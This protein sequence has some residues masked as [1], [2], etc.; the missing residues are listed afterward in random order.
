M[1]VE[2]ARSAAACVITVVTR[3]VRAAAG[4]FAPG[5]LGE[6]IQ[7]VP[8]EMVDAVLAE[9]GGIQRR[10]RA[11]PSRVVVY[12]LLAGALFAELGYRQVWARLTAG[13]PEPGVA[14]SSSALAQARRRVGAA[15]LKALFELLRGPAAVAVA[16]G[17]VRWRGLLVCGID[18]T[19]ISVP[20][21][22]ANLAAYRRQSGSAFAMLRLVTV[23][24]C[25]TAA[26][27]AR[28]SAAPLMA[29]PP[30]PPGSSAPWVSR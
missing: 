3:P 1:P 20:D 18:G 24:A 2:A 23:V 8:F 28:C 5:H 4:V 11:L 12:V 30:T 29:R 21:S 19:I 7:I 13:L 6:L 22:P 9:A 26:S 15:P 10:V 17:G 16:G 14:P 27:S 25:G